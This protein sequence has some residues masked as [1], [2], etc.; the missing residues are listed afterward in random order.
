MT[1]EIIKNEVLSTKKYIHKP[2]PR[3]DMFKANSLSGKFVSF[4][5]ERE[6]KIGS[7][8]NNNNNQNSNSISNTSNN[9]YTTNQI[10]KTNDNQT[11]DNTNINSNL[12]T[13]QNQNTHT[14]N[15]FSSDVKTNRGQ[16][17]LRK[18]IEFS[19]VLSENSK[20]T[21]P[22]LFKNNGLNVKNANKVIKLK[23]NE[24]N[25]SVKTNENI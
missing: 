20:E 2:S 6:K 13:N 1:N 5:K 11:K 17:T 8:N 21:K 4:S 12:M 19:K 9:T 15:A 16:I 18:S 10:I 14:N 23:R 7:M 22:I 24:S 25:I 3:M